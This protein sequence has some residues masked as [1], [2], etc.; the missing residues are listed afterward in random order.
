MKTADDKPVKVCSV[1]GQPIRRDRF[2]CIAHW[3]LV[4][5]AMQVAVWRSFRA[6]QKRRTPQEGKVA[7]AEYRSATD[8]AT[9]FVSSIRKEPQP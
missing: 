1:C 5:T 7:L 3:R 8:A 4:P 9:Q 6:F 2:M